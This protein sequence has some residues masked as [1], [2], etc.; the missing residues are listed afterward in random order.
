MLCDIS[1]RVE[2]QTNQTNKLIAVLVAALSGGQI[3]PQAVEW[4][5]DN[6]EAIE[7][8][9]IYQT[10]M[11]Y[12]AP[13]MAIPDLAGKIDQQEQQL[14]KVIE[15]IGGE[16]HEIPANPDYPQLPEIPWEE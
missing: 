2:E 14:A 5:L 16:T 9:E 7:G 6:K 11:T 4:L 10:V 1:G 8:N 13:I 15:L 3:P 12:V